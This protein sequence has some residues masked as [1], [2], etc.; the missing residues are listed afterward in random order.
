MNQN[1][2]MGILFSIG[3][4][5]ILV[6]ITPTSMFNWIMLVLASILSVILIIIGAIYDPKK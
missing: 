4:L 6:F 3:L 2:A 5:Y 1:I